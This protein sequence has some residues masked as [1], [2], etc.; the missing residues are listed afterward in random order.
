MQFIRKK[1]ISPTDLKIHHA[2]E[3]RLGTKYFQ[4]IDLDSF[5]N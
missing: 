5:R 2:S 3:I 4:W 1:C